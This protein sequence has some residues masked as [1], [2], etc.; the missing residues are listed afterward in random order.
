[1]MKRIV[2][3]VLSLVCVLLCFA[4]CSHGENDK[5]AY[6]R[7]YLSEPVY[8][9]DPLNAFDNQATLQ[10]V[11]LIYE[12]LFAVDDDGDV[13]GA[14]VDE[15]EYVADEDK[16]VYKLIL[17][18]KETHWSDGV[19]LTASDAQYAFL[20]LFSSSVSHPATAMLFDI[21][22]AKSIAAGDDSV[23]HLG[24]SVADPLTLEIE[25]EGDIDIDTFLPVLTS[26]ALYPLRADKIDTNK[27]W[28][29]FGN[30]LVCSGPFIVNAMDYTAKDGFMLERNGYYYRDRAKDDV[31]EYVTPFRIVVDYKTPGAEQLAKFN[32]KE[33]GALYYLNYIPLS[34]RTDENAEILKKL[35]VTA[36][37]STHV[38]YM[39]QAVAPFDNASVRN[40]LSLALDREA[41]ANAI[42][43]A[44]AAGSLVPQ[45]IL[46]RADRST[47]FRDKAVE[48]LVTSPK[49]EEAKQLLADAKIKASDYS[50]TLTVNAQSEEHVKMGELAV[51][52]WK[53]LGFKVTLNKLDVYEI[54][55]KDDKGRDVHTG[56]YSSAYREA[57]QSG[58]FDVIA[59]DL[60]S[61]SPTAFSYLA[62]FAKAYS[63]NGYSTTVDA[64]GKT[65]YT[66][67]PHV[68]GYD[69][70]EFNAKIDAAAAEKKEKKRAALLEE[71]EE[72]LLK[73]MPV[74]P[75]VYNK[76]TTLK[77]SKLSGVK[78]GFY[79]PSIFT[80]AKLSGYWKIAL[81]DGFVSTEEEE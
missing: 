58:S 67:N 79:T 28:S 21:K 49:L 38:Y 70:E 81:R 62:P 73:D 45:S 18:L 48:H 12:G 54:L 31:D 56:A 51:A 64:E 8:D 24:V 68:T 9:F 61:T 55:E 37:N 3:L 42:V 60:V 5:G 72:I 74:I 33:A 47:T 78:A 46:Y 13:D 80:K 26:P 69:S 66:L 35:D 27:N 30:D 2:A 43:Y 29:K 39:N 20:R 53:Q 36:S 6:I 41:I 25:F 65:V 22:N 14:L 71:A 7:M 17:T 44:E 63:G 50:F 32:S 57:L 19:Q 40:A 23:D 52:A 77:S 16:N 4:G 1:M 59:L 15:Y 10:I 34:A 76:N 11:S 75:V